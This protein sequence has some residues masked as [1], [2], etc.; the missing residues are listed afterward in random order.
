[1]SGKCLLPN[2]GPDDLFV[3]PALIGVL[4]ARNPLTAGCGSEG[5]SFAFGIL[6]GQPKPKPGQAIGRWP[7]LPPQ[8]LNRAVPVADSYR[9]ARRSIIPETWATAEKMSEQTGLPA[10]QHYEAL[11][12]LF[13]RPTLWERFVLHCDDRHWAWLVIEVVWVAGLFVAIAFIFS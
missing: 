1:M 8:D 4:F 10:Q 9:M 13:R 12:D 2:P 7:S 11:V 5:F 3:S 6:G